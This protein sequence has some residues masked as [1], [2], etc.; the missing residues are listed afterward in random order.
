M[1]VASFFTSSID[2][3]TLTPP[4]LPRPP[5]WICAFTT[6][7]GP[8]SC[9]A[10]CTASL[11]VNAGIP[12]GTG[13]PN[14]LSTALAW[15]SWMFMGPLS[16]AEIGRDLLASLDQAFHRG[17][18]LV[19]L[20]A[21][22]ARQVELDDALGANHHRHADVKPLHAVLA[23]QPGG[24]GQ[25]ALLVEQVALR[26][27]DGGRS[28]RVERRAGLEQVDDLGA[29]V[30]GAVEDLIGARLRG[31]AHFDQVGQRDAGDR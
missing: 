28:R 11:A 3:T 1:R 29:A 22:G 23:V 8:G 5:A 20:G 13:T 19:E 14:S 24:A 12:F 9:C 30:A 27:R 15:Y 25:H 16:L 21:F 31:P 7:T 4:A 2:F 17:D 18:R 10:A 26:H 6:H